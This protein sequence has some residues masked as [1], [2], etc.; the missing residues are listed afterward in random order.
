MTTIN[1]T[2][3]CQPP[4]VPSTPNPSWGAEA[5]MDTPTVNGTAYPVMTVDP[6]PYRLKFLN[7]AHDRFFNLQMYVADSTVDPN[8]TNSPTAL[9]LVALVQPKLKSPWSLRPLI[10]VDFGYPDTWPQDGRDGGVPDYSKSGPDWIMYASEGGF[11]PQPVVIPQQPVDWNVDVTTFNAGNV[12]AG[13]FILGPAERGEVVV[14]FTAFA[15]QTLILYNDAPAPWPALD[16]H[17]DY[18]TGAP[19]RLISVVPTATLPGLGPNTRTIMKIVVNNSPGAEFNLAAMQDAFDQTTGSAF[20][21]GQDQ[22]IVAQGNM[23]PTGDPAFYEAFIHGDRSATAV[24]PDTTATYYTGDY[25]VPYTGLSN[26]YGSTTIPTNYPNW[27][28]ARI[29]DKGINFVGVDGDTTYA[30]D[31][32]D[33]TAHPL[34]PGYDLNGGIPLQFKA[35]QDEQGETFDDYGRM[36]AGLGIENIAAGAGV[37]NFVI[38]TYSDPATEILE[39]NGIQVWKITHNGVDTHPVHFHLYD[40]QVLNRVGW[41]GFIRLPDPTEAGWKETVRISPLEDTI[42]ALKP[43]TPMVPFGVPESIRPLNPAKPLGD[44]TELT[45]IDPFT[46]TARANLNRN[47]QSRLGIRLALSHPQP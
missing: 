34:D 6:K 4:E 8:A 25:S 29:N 13:S 18:Y 43:V 40:V 45:Q 11:L 44:T 5:F 28:V 26:A 38:Q 20:Q 21:D 47:G 31:A 9:H 27:G 17:Y 35:I 33:N 12:N 2:K 23:N 10:L 15:G 24:A 39:E 3:F 32:A 41:D 30:Y 7:A 16:P 1:G 36:R 22:L 42:V 19:D 37:V 46:G 14:D